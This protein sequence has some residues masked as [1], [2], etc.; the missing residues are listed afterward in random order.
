M[1]GLARKL[2]FFGIGSPRPVN[3]HSRFTSTR[4]APAN[5]GFTSENPQPSTA[6][7]LWPFAR[8]P[9]THSS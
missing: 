1:D 7:P 6:G 9:S 2:K 8:S 3:G 4:S 5:S